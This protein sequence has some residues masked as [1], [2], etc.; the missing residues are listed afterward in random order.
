M[1]FLVALNV[2]LDS[3]LGCTSGCALVK[4]NDRLRRGN[5]KTST[6]HSHLQKRM[7]HFRTLDWDMDSLRA[8]LVVLEFVRSNS[9]TPDRVVARSI[10]YA[11]FVGCVTGVREGLSIS[12]NFRPRH[13]CGGFYLRWHQMLVLFGVRRSVISLLRRRLLEET[14]VGLGLLAKETAETLTAPCYLVF[15]DGDETVVIEKDLRVCIQI[16][17]F[18]PLVT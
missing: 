16:S 3:M 5:K 2:L 1:Y 8:V 9:P 13:Y 11:G 6:P 10:T 7:M 4:P 18:R 15:C 17:S 12:L 14:G